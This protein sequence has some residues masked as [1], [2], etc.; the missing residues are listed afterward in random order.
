MKKNTRIT[1]LILTLAMCIALLASCA[2]GTPAATSSASP[3]PSASAPASASPAPSAPVPQVVQTSAPEPPPENVKFAEEVNIIDGTSAISVI[4]YL[5][6]AG[7]SMPTHYVYYMIYDRL[8]E[9]VGEGEY[10]PMLATS[11]ETTDYKTYIFHL[12][13][14]VYFHNGEKFTSADVVYTINSAQATPGVNAYDWWRSVDTVK[15]L[16]DYTVEIVLTDVNVMFLYSVTVTA[17]GIINQK[18][19]EEDPEKGY[20]VGTGPYTVYDFVSSISVTCAINPNYWGRPGVTERITIWH[21]PELSARTIMMQNKESEFAFEILP[22][23]LHLFQDNPDYIIIPFI[24]INIWPLTFNMNDPILSDKN[25]RLAVAYALRKDEIAY[26]AA[27]PE[28][29]PDEEGTVYG[30]STEFRNRDIPP[31]PYDPVKAKEYLDASIY[32]GEELEIVVAL[33]PNVA[34]VPMIVSQLNEIG[35]NVRINQMDSP[36]LRSYVT[37]TDNNQ[38]QLIFHTFS[39]VSN[40]SNYNSII[41]TGAANNFASYSNPRVDELLEKGPTVTNTEERKAVYYEI[42]EIIAEDMPYINL[43]WKLQFCVAVKGV[44]GASLNSDMYHDFRYIYQVLDD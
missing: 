4:N 41:R 38:G 6:P 22:E 15:A 30:Y 26:A 44:G 23:D 28:A 33:P 29:V 36:S 1:T 35:I 18:A 5:S 25:F 39:P 42:Q 17:T 32:N 13:D 9:V 2:N 14:D 16:D 27:G 31:I 24:S 20:W 34:A 19:I 11:Y 40:P 7:N 3:A 10:G 37:P 8:L 43:F 21:I 12:R